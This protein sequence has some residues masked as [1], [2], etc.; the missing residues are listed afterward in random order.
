MTPS[1]RQVIDRYEERVEQRGRRLRDFLDGNGPG[2][3]IVQQPPGT[4]WTKCNSVEEVYRSNI[5]YVR[6]ALDVDWTDD[7]PYLEP[8]VGTGVYAA[9]FGCEYVFRDGNPPHVHYRCH[10]IDEV[11]GVEYPD[12]RKCP[13]MTM[14][15]NCIDCLK[16]RT[17]GKI[18]ISLTD[19]QSPF[20]TATLVVDACELFAACYTDEQIVLDLMQK[21]T[22][23]IIEFSQVQIERI[24]PKLVARPGHQLPSVAGGPGFSLSDDNLAVSSPEINQKIA[25]PLDKQLA[26]TFGGLAVHSCGEWAHTMPMLREMSNILA[27]ECAVGAGSGDPNPNAPADVRRAL[28]G[29]SIFAKVRLGDDISKALATLEELADGQLKLVVQI[30]Y[31]EENAERNYRLI[32][33]RLQQIYLC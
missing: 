24:G 10:E 6:D 11:R 26:D 16:E 25:L 2:F 33:E 29:S 13:I 7:L 5:Q 20:D 18:P 8:W 22:D 30:G 31:D 4:V 19:T 12:W 9:A 17:H 23:L 32:Q 27:V 3:L 15:L 21:I 1:I 14:V 28:T